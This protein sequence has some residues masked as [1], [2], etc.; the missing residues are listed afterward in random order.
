MG[1]LLEKLFMPAMAI[2]QSEDRADA[3]AKMTDVGMALALFRSD[4]GEY[5][6]RLDQLTPKFLSSLPVDPFG[7]GPFH[8]RRTDD[9][10]LLY[11]VGVNGQDDGGSGFG[12]ES[13]SGD[14]ILS[15]AG[16]PR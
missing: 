11:S 14:D 8:Y 6:D 4:R 16:K 10:F 7:D 15:R 5:P 13:E 1:T 9:G 12:G 2:Q 3:V